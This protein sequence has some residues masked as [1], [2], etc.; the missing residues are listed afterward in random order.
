M[1]DI[2]IENIGG[3]RWYMVAII[4][5]GMYFQ[6]QKFGISCKVDYLVLYPE[7]NTPPTETSF[8]DLLE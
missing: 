8:S 5:K 1:T 6:K 2:P 3:R 7:D 4:L